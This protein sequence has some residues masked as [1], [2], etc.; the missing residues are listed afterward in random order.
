MI[1]FAHDTDFLA[2]WASLA[3]VGKFEMPPRRFA[4]GVAFFRGQGPGAGGQGGRIVAVHGLEQAQRELG[5]LV[6]DAKLP[7]VGQFS[8]SSYEGEGFAIVRHADTAVVE[9]ALRV[10]VSTVRVELGAA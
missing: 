3:A 8:N 10:L 6:V 5:H 7:Q 2:R 4:A 9:K 1:S